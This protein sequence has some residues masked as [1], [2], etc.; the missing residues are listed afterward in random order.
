MSSKIAQAS[1][2]V[3]CYCLT[4]ASKF[5]HHRSQRCQNT[6]SPALKKAVNGSIHSLLIY[7]G[8]RRLIVDLDYRETIFELDEQVKG[9]ISSESCLMFIEV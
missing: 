7:D 5:V 2:I 4:P 8:I 1:K 6:T 9:I 3:M